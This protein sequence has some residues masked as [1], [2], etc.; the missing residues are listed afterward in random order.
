MATSA[1]RVGK[2]AQGVCMTHEESG[3]P[4]HGLLH[5][6][7]QDEIAREEVMVEVELKRSEGCSEVAD[8][9]A[10]RHRIAT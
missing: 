5:A 2:A 3:E 6:N 7:E 10:M 1:Q 9:R 4:S 8:S